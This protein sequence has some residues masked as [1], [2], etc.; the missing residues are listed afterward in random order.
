MGRDRIKEEKDYEE[1]LSVN[2]A[3]QIQRI[4]EELIKL[5]PGDIKIIAKNES[6]KKLI[7]SIK[8]N[9]ITI[10]AGPAGT[11]KTFVAMAYALSLLRKSGNRFRKIYLMKS[12]TT[13][14]GEE[15]GFLKGDLKEKI[16][17]FMWSFYIS[18][19]KILLDSS[20]KALIDKDI[21]RPFPLAYMR[22]VSLDDCIIIADE[23]QNVTLDNAHTLLTRIGSNS[24]LILLG[25][26]DQIDMKNKLES[27]LEVLVEMFEDTHSMGVI[28]MS[29]EDTNVR[30]PL[31]SIIEE[32][33][34]EFF[35]N[36]K[37]VAMIDATT[38][39]TKIIT[40]HKDKIKELNGD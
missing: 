30:N 18:M 27:S 34:K 10:C 24:K 32:K 6:Q 35:A 25:D 21:I 11:G 17:P 33:F 13:L 37:R 3:V 7:N 19:E 16:E 22:G 36:K 15:I 28:E 1:L 9:E 12:V 31:I 20:I 5:L 23:M 4:K 8:N 14:K 2:S 39:G 40:I 26:M 38:G 29:Q